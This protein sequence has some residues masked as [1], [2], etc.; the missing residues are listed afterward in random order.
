MDRPTMRGIPTG[1]LK[2]FTQTT[3]LARWMLV[4]GMLLTAVFVV[5]ALFAPWIAPYGFA[6]ASPDPAAAP[7][8]PGGER[9]SSL[10]KW[11]LGTC[12]SARS[13]SSRAC[14]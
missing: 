1:L 4:A 9:C 11:R 10:V 8:G 13:R 7:L 3:G 2:P 5:C 12:T 14:E 6:Q